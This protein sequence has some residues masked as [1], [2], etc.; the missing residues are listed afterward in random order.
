MIKIDKDRGE[1]YKNNIEIEF[2]RLLAS[3]IVM[4]IKILLYYKIK[5]WNAKYKNYLDG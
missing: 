1:S 3:F 5:N 4:I 2:K